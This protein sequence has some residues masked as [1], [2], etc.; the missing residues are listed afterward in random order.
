[1]RWVLL[2]LASPSLGQSQGLGLWML[3]VLADGEGVQVTDP[4][5]SLNVLLGLG[6]YGAV[7]LGT[8]L[9]SSIVQNSFFIHEP[10]IYEP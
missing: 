2:H 10:F 8:C 6:G 1:M 7:T 4:L 9:K 5:G 3:E